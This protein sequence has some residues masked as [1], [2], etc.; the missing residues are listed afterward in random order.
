[1]I[2]GPAAPS[3]PDQGGTPPHSPDHPGTAHT[4]AIELASSIAE[5]LGVG[6]RVQAEGLP[7]HGWGGSF[8]HYRR[9]QSHFKSKQALISIE[10]YSNHNSIIFSECSLVMPSISTTWRMY[11]KTERR[12]HICE[13]KFYRNSSDG[14]TNPSMI[15]LGFTWKTQQH[16]H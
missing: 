3:A 10:W 13:N 6:T 11:V 7:H 16:Q 4:M 2:F 9:P 1:M 8:G 15:D 12:A 5:L 14:T